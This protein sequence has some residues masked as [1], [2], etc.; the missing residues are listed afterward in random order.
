MHR[1]LLASL[2]LLAAA[3]APTSVDAPGMPAEGEP[4]VVTY[5]YLNF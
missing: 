1:P 2:S 3:C 4:L 5:Y